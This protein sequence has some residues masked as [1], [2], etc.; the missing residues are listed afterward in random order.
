MALAVI[1]ALPWT[2]AWAILAA[3]LLSGRWRGGSLLLALALYV[4]S[5]T[6]A[7]AKSGGPEVLRTWLLLSAAPAPLA[8]LAWPIAN[9]RPVVLA[10]RALNRCPWCGSSLTREEALAEEGAPRR[11]ALRCRSCDFV[12]SG[13]EPATSAGRA[14][15]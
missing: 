12:G 6:V 11:V 3:R 4:V 2:A 8:L 13:M 7:L 5:A 14:G 1:F 9:F 15:A 10:A